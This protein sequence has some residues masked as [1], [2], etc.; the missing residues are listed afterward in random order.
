[1]ARVYSIN[2]M[3]IVRLIFQM[4]FIAFFLGQYWY[5]FTVTLHEYMDDFNEPNNYFADNEDWNIDKKDDLHINVIGM[6]FAFTT[7]STVGFGDYYPRNDRER[8]VW[9]PI[10]LSG[11]AMFSYFM[12]FLLEMLI[13]VKDLDKEFNNE[14]ELE[15]FF[16]L[17]QYFNRG[18]SMDPQLS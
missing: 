3:K 18:R 9:A 12:G 1:M 11:V 4:M 16:G 5:V 7:I 10:L 2:I 17:M 8:A 13:K 6:Y 15:K 14:E